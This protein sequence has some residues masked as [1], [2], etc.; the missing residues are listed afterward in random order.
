M[1][2]ARLRRLSPGVVAVGL[3]L[4]GLPLAGRGAAQ[5]G[6]AKDESYL[7]Q[8]RR[9][10]EVAAQR[11]EA[12]VRSAMRAAQRLSATDPAGAVEALKTTLARLET[13][14]TLPDDR[15]SGLVRAVKDRIRVT[16]SLARRATPRAEPRPQGTPARRSPTDSR[17]TEGQTLSLSLQAVRGL[18]KDGQVAEARRQVED[19]ARRYPDNPAV[20]AARRTVSSVDQLGGIRGQRGDSERR[21]AAAFNDTDRSALPPLGEVEFPKD[22]A[23]KSEKR[24]TTIPLTAKERA[25]LLALNKP[26]SVQFKD[27]RFQEVIDSLSNA[28]GQPIL[29]DENALK[30]AQVNYDTP[31]TAQVRG[32]AARTLLRKILGEFG[33]AYVVKDQTLQVTSALKAKELMVVRSYYLGD[34][35]GNA[36]F[37]GFLGLP[38]VGDNNPVQVSQQVNQIMDLIQNS[39]EP[40]SW[41]KN[42]GNGTITF[43]APTMSLVIR[44]SAEVHAILAGGVKP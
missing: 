36:G 27:T 5:E 19:L 42:G 15:R 2:Q 9:R 14:D 13:D 23:D 26:V 20:L 6:P 17:L 21:L 7:E 28:M 25:I 33:L 11:V 10:N 31:I 35:L 32:V 16:E 8:V 44:Q 37:G 12:E 22:W 1:S 29:L 40:M 43:H 24:A 34:L 30:E 4:V 18:L 39:V 41:Q 38:S 3:L